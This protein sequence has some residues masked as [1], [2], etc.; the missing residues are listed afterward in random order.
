MAL[1]LATSCKKDEI[2]S[3]SGES[4]IYFVNKG[5]EEIEYS[6]SFHPGKERDTV[7]LVI[8]LIGQ[9]SDMDRK[10]GIYVDTDSTT[11]AASDFL[12]PSTFV[13]RGGHHRDTIPLVLVKSA[14]LRESKYRISL[15]I[16]DEQELLT[17]PLTNQFLTIVFS[18]MI[19]KPAWWDAAM[20]SNFLGVYSD[21]KY[22]FFIEATG[23]A[24]LTGMSESEKRA[25]ALI[26]RDF[27]RKGRD[28]GKTFVD[29]NG[30]PVTVPEGLFS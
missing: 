23:I 4:Y 9:I 15:K 27:L 20:T 2:D 18:D 29:E 11:A 28:E 7:P 26:F 13:L 12:L 14:K 1:S 24:D 17:G 8:A 16:R 30:D 25:Y 19:S 3:Y 22:R 10:V 6:F 5:S 21:A